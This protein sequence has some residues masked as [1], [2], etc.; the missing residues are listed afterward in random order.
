MLIILI[1]IYYLNSSTTSNVGN[2]L[3]NQHR[4]TGLQS[5]AKRFNSIRTRCLEATAILIGG[6]NNVRVT[7][8]AISNLESVKEGVIKPPQYF[9]HHKFF[10]GCVEES[11][12]MI[13]VKDRTE[14]NYFKAMFQSIVHLTEKITKGN[15]NPS[16]E[17]TLKS[18]VNSFFVLIENMLESIERTEDGFSVAL[19]ILEELKKLPV[20]VLTTMKNRPVNDNRKYPPAATILQLMLKKDFIRTAYLLRGSSLK[21]RYL[22][23]FEKLISISASSKDNGLAALDIVLITVKNEVSDLFTVATK[24]HL[25]SSNSSKNNSNDIEMK[26]SLANLWKIVA[27]YFKNH[28][29]KHSE[30][31]QSKT[32]S[33]NHDLSACKNVLL[34]PFEM[35]PDVSS[36]AVWNKWADLYRQ[37]NMLAALVV[38]YKSLELERYL[39]QE[40]SK[41]LLKASPIAMQ[42][43][44]NFCQYL[45]QQMV[46]SIPFPTYQ[47]RDSESSAETSIKEIKPVVELLVELSRKALSTDFRDK[48][49]FLTGCSTLCLQLTNIL[50]NV[51]NKGMIRQLFKHVVPALVAFLSLYSTH[52]HGFEKQVKDMYDQALSM[53]NAGYEEHSSVQILLDAKKFIV[54]ALAHSNRDVRSKAYQMWLQTFANSVRN[55][56]IP[57]EVN[58]A[59]KN[60]SGIISFDS[61]ISS[62]S[63]NH[64]DG[65]FAALKTAANPLLNFGHFF[66]RG[67]QENEIF[68]DSPSKS[69]PDVNIEHPK[70]PTSATKWIKPT[71]K[72]NS[73]E[74][75]SR[76]RKL[77]IEDE[78][79]QDFVKIS[80][81][82]VKK[83]PLTDH[84]KDLMTSRRDDIPALYSELSRDDSQVGPL[85]AQFNSQNLLEAKTSMNSPKTQDEKSNS[86]LEHSINDPNVKIE[87]DI[88]HS[89]DISKEYSMSIIAPQKNHEKLIPSTKEIYKKG[90]YS[91][92][93][94]QM[95]LIFA[96]DLLYPYSK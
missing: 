93:T 57:K 59:L 69:I 79:S 64:K 20:N 53:L 60:H 34:H 21:D 66:D 92:W 36:R 49:S 86:L 44:V 68:K 65:T 63:Q 61:S 37:I 45:S 96:I 56:D 32:A 71:M 23:V 39:S 17:E 6:L 73:S 15:I 16:Y 77:L 1:Q 42:S 58:D 3:S 27:T 24:A 11:F 90:R 40:G 48:K 67:K 83:R 14:V 33:L 38:T 30:V 10:L 35:F 76:R 2:G 29:D 84:Q 52:G 19:M 85:P 78:S 43:F 94:L 62:S 87:K 55:Q 25:V 9:K 12:G 89:E 31:N 82:G 95:E 75:N 72:S 22:A 5:P 88:E 91:I 7:R 70:T 50:A 41:L 74:K 51:S 81:P 46:S 26:N 8:L 80:S 13:N 4:L 28:I 47:D 18:V 54:C